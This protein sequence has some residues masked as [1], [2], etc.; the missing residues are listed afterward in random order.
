MIPVMTT[1]PLNTYLNL[2]RFKNTQIPMTVVIGIF[3]EINY[4][5]M[6]FS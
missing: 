6:S 5:Y 4:I 3:Y 1:Y 2:M